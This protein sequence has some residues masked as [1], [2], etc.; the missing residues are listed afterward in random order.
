MHMNPNFALKVALI[1]DAKIPIILL[2]KNKTKEK[3]TSVIRT[4]LRA[5]VLEYDLSFLLLIKL[6][7]NKFELF[8]ELFANIK[9]ST[10]QAK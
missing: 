3:K 5:Q 8:N 2:K 7:L 9:H 1:N 6:F 4:R 10:L